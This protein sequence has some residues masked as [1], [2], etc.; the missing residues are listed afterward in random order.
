MKRKDLIGLHCTSEYHMGVSGIVKDLYKENDIW[1]VLIHDENYDNDVRIDMSDVVF[2]YPY[3]NRWEFEYYNSC[4]D[5]DGDEK[6]CK[7]KLWLDA[8]IDEAKAIK[9][10]SLLYAG[11]NYFSLRNLKIV[12]T[13]T[14]ELKVKKYD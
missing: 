3:I 8:K 7:A 1:K 12:E 11:D 5:I 4:Y 9:I 10:I 13:R 14:K 6:F 2:D